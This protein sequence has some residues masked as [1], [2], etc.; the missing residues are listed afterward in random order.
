M[1]LTDIKYKV[2][3]H[4]SCT[5]WL[6]NVFISPFKRIV[7]INHFKKKL[8][9][10]MCYICLEY[11]GMTTICY[12]QDCQN[13]FHVEC[14]RRIFCE[15]ALP[16]QLNSKQSAHVSYCIEHS[17][18]YTTR[19]KESLANLYRF[20][21]PKFFKKIEENHHSDLH[22]KSPRKSRSKYKIVIQLRRFKRRKK[23]VFEVVRNFLRV[24]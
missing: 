18:S 3:C 2:W 11:T 15:Q 16:Y 12:N 17:K 19:K 14:A 23:W 1:F 7:Q 10:Q 4:L 21:Y 20:R 22:H 8:N 9:K 5:Y 6:R 13:Y 24:N